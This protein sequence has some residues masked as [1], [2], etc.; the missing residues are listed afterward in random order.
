MRTITVRD[1]PNVPT[2][3]N[4]I[5]ESYAT[6]GSIIVFRGIPAPAFRMMQMSRVLLERQRTIGE[7]G[8]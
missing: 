1:V 3:R 6:H 7:F 4:D 8:S 5:G 2:A